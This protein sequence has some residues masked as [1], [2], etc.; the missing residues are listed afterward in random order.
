MAK[1]VCPNC[2]EMN[3]ENAKV[4]IVC[5]NSL[6]DVHILGIS[7]KSKENIILNHSYLCLV[8]GRSVD[9]K[10]KICPSCGGVCTES[11][12]RYE[13]STYYTTKDNDVS[14]GIYI[15]SFLIP[16]A[17]IIIGAIWI[18]D[19]DISKK[20]NGKSVLTTAIVSILIFTI[21]N[22]LFI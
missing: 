10:T 17:G 16:L 12:S 11:K 13:S 1:K 8:C 15:L 4:C 2:N 19:D 20:D 3:G 22:I 21:L 5:G 18:A 7:E 6:K 9:S 14:F